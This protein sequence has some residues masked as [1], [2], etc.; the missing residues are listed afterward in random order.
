MREVLLILVVLLVACTDQPGASSARER[1]ASALGR[2]EGGRDEGG[3]DSG[4][5]D[6]GG[7]DGG[8]ATDAGTM[9]AGK[10]T[11]S[12]T[13]PLVRPAFCDSP[14]N[15]AVH[16]AFC[17]D[18]AP[19]VADLLT[20]ERLLGFDLQKTSASDDGVS[21]MDGGWDD[22]AGEGGG[23]AEL[24]SRAVLLGLSTALSGRMVSPINPRAILIGEETFIAYQRGVQ[25]V[26]VATHDRDSSE[27]NFYLASFE[28]AC[29]ADGCSHGDLFTERVEQNW[30]RLSLQDDEELKNSPLDC[31][32]CHQRGRETPILLMRELEG[33]WNHFFTNDYNDEPQTLF[34]EPMG[35]ELVEDYRRARGDEPYAG[36]PI[37]VVRGTAGLT[38]QAR[39]DRHQP[40]LFDGNDILNERWPWADG[41]FAQ[42]PERSAT[43]DKN[44]ESFR[45]GET[46][47]LP[48]YQT[49]PTDP[50][51]QARLTERY[52]Q[53]RS[54]VI[55]A[56]ELPDLADIYPDDPVMRAEIGL[57]TAPDDSPVTLLIT[58]CG[59]CHND[60][61][62]QTISRARFNIDLA[63]M[64]EA[65]RK[66]AVERVLRAPQDPG[67]MPP[68]ESRQLTPEAR[69]RLTAYL[70]SGTR[71][72]ED[73]TALRHAA[74]EG[75]AALP[76]PRVT[77]SP[78]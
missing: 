70:Q 69:D 68:P 56:E 30:T 67:V 19:P 22:H 16:D 59:S 25:Q 78:F 6:S 43:W 37:S 57:Q 41:G 53:Y 74:K 38:L 33:P 34:P 12:R 10:K 49:R 45:R 17:A 8:G 76:P 65:E 62:D 60:V 2:D 51:K 72:A 35:R 50:E 11:G 77:E 14:K 36:L 24:S 42:Q 55:S 52:T 13:G 3:R 40:L 61:L 23:Y 21:S 63:T 7:R 64:D 44:Y 47:Q 28:Q 18:D 26:E 9:D 1:D 15:D 32:Q 46:L 73:D 31:R 4:G 66:L 20:F 27:F 39:V 5:R 29:N 48:H 54:G 71:D 58:A 75:M